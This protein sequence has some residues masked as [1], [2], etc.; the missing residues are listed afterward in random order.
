MAFLPRALRREAQKKGAM[1]Y[2]IA[3]RI[4]SLMLLMRGLSIGA[5]VVGVVFLGAALMLKIGL[6]PLHY[7]VPG[8]LGGMSTSGLYLL[9]SWQKIAPLSLVWFTAVRQLPWAV[10]N[11]AGGRLLMLGATSLPLLL[12]FRGMVQ[13]G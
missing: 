3:Q 7:W 8:V 2:F 9:L 13:I 5:L 1:G 10:G 11:A 12:V 6:L 4:G